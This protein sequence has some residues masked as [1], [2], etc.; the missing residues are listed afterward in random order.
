VL[1][2]T[3]QLP[4]ALLPAWLP[5]SY[6]TQHQAPPEPGVSTCV[7]GEEWGGQGWSPELAQAGLAGQQLQ[8][9]LLQ[10]NL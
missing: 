5:V 4:A 10:V 7:Q 8:A 6:D 2:P 1:H 9:S 3:A